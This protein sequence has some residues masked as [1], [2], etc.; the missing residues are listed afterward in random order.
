MKKIIALMVAF[1]LL[2][3]L[4]SC[5]KTGEEDK[6]KGEEAGA[7][8]DKFSEALL[9]ITDGNAYDVTVYADLSLGEGSNFN[10]SLDYQYKD[11]GEAL[12][13]YEKS[14]FQTVYYADGVKTTITGDSETQENVSYEEMKE[15]VEASTSM[16]SSFEITREDF[17]NAKIEKRD[18]LTTVTVKRTGITELPDAFSGYAML[19]GFNE[20]EV[21]DIVYDDAEF[22]LEY[23]DQAE[24]EYINLTAGVSYTNA[25]GTPSMFKIIVDLYVNAVGDSVKVR[26]Y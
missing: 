26:K 14:I 8:F 25:E 12:E 16:M 18:D 11:S 15:S 23:N 7:A 17:E 10:V 13:Y 24:L 9:K 4:V 6:E 22:I 2:F 21:T 19:F 20:N 5:G 3:A 1:V